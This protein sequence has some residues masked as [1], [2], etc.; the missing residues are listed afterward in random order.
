MVMKR[1]HLFF[2][3]GGNVALA[4]KTV[5]MSRRS[6]A[7]RQSSGLVSTKSLDGGPPELVT[8]MS[9]RPKRLDGG[10]EM[11]DGVGICDVH[12]LIE[13]FPASGFLDLR[14]G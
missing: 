14:G 1:P 10:D 9:M 4:K 11:R 2:C 8:Q 12:S 6:T 3:M 13:D 5:L 7:A